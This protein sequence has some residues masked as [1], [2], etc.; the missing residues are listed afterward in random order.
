MGKTDKKR[1]IK[2]EKI[3]DALSRAHY[4][5]QDWFI[6]LSTNSCL[7]FLVRNE[8]NNLDMLCYV[9]ANILMVADTGS[10]VEKIDPTP[11]F[12]S[13]ISVWNECTSQTFAIFIQNGLIIKRSGSI[14]DSYSVTKDKPRSGDIEMI[15]QISSEMTALNEDVVEIVD[16]KSAIEIVTDDINPFDVLI[17]GG[18][19]KIEESKRCE[20]CQPTILINYKGFTYGQTIPFVNIIDLMNSLKGYEVTLAKNSK[21]I[22]EYQSQKIKAN[23]KEALEI[24]KKFTESLESSLKEW[25]DEWTSSSELLNRIQTILEKAYSGKHPMNDIPSRAN[26]ALKETQEK[27]IERRDNLLGLLIHTKEVF[28]EV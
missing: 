23:G 6:D 22:L 20:D 24:L 18:D 8:I 7:F 1:Q 14:W 25:D 9:P 15:H 19:I 16:E 28:S 27:L 2:R 10:Y 17:D 26:L 12:E 3:V 4:S 21:D 11:D 5:I 13:S